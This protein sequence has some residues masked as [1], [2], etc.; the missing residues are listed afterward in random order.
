[1]RLIEKIEGYS[2]MTADEKLAALES[3]EYEAYSFNNLLYW[4]C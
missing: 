2:E 3:F 1:M 4:I